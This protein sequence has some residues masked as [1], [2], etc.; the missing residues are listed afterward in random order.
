MEFLWRIAI[1]NHLK[2]SII[3]KRRNKVGVGGTGL[4]LKILVVTFFFDNF[5]ATAHKLGQNF[6]I[7]EFLMVCTTTN[8]ALLQNHPN[9]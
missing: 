7:F 4:Y 9:S 5:E 2:L 6:Q 3:E 1:Q 8:Q